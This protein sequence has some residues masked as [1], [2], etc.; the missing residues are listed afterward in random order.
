MLYWN[1]HAHQQSISVSTTTASSFFFDEQL[2]LTAGCACELK[3]PT[4]TTTIPIV[5]DERVLDGYHLTMPSD[6]TCN[7]LVIQ[8][9][10]TIG[11]GF[12]VVILRMMVVFWV[13]GAETV[14]F[15]SN[16][17]QR[18]RGRKKTAEGLCVIQLYGISHAYFATADDKRVRGLFDNGVQP[19]LKFFEIRVKH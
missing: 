7:T 1:I 3:I 11:K 14:F 5:N 12:Q 9:R 2:T 4:T 17:M 6:G 19:E 8:E 13:V 10:T 18:R 15:F 16:G